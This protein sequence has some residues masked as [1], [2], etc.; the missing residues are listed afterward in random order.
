VIGSATVGTMAKKP[1]MKEVIQAE[2]TLSTMSPLR[3]GSISSLPES[4]KI[5]KNI[6]EQIFDK[7]IDRKEF[8]MLNTQ[9]FNSRMFYT[10]R[11][12]NRQDES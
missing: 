1:V 6:N 12:Q 9:H 8:Q 11:L 3:S 2:D 10:S 5:I 4:L 7:E